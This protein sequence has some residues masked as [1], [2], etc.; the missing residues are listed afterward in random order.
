MAARRRLLSQRK[1]NRYLAYVINHK[2]S[3]LVRVG[4]EPLAS[5]DI[6]DNEN[7]KPSFL[8]RTYVRE[9]LKIKAESVTNKPCM[10]TS[11]KIIENED[12]EQRLTGQWSKNKCISSH[13]EV[14]TCAIHEQEIV[15]KDL[16]YRRK[17]K[18][19]QMTTNGASAK[20]TQR[21]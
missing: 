19:L 20:S 21:M 13:F 8:G 15:T 16:I 12:A 11:E 3:N 6:D 7:W 4:R 1:K 17:L 9:V 14:Y 2:E 18:N 5:K 10:I